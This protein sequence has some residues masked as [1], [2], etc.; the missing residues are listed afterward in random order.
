MDKFNGLSLKNKLAVI[1]APVAVIAAFA[2]PFFTAGD[3]SV[4]WTEENNKALIGTIA[5][6]VGAVFVLLGNKIVAL[7]GFAVGAFL[8]LVDVKDIFEYDGISL[9]IGAI[10]LLAAVAVGLWATITNLAAKKA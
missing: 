5:I 7:A 9:G 10:L 3:L 4:K 8:L 1:A 6:V 2:L